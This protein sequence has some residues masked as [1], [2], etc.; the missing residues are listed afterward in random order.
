ME[1]LELARKRRNQVIILVIR[2]QQILVASTE[3]YGV[4]D[5]S[6][7]ASGFSKMS[8]VVVG[9]H[10]RPLQLS[11][12]HVV[13]PQFILDQCSAVGTPRHQGVGLLFQ[14]GKDLHLLITRNILQIHRDLFLGPL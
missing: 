9:G 6:A 8:L 10:W 1:V 13:P 2:E 7:F 11:R 12:L 5:A 3:R 4:V 14:L